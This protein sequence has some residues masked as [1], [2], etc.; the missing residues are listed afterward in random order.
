M[1]TIDFSQIIAAKLNGQEVVRISDTVNTLW[2]KQ[3]ADYNYLSFTDVS[4]AQNTLTLSRVGTEPTSLYNIALEYSFDK[5]TWQTWTEDANYVRTLA[6][7]AGGT[8]YLRGDNSV[9]NLGSDNY[10]YNFASTANVAAGGDLR[11]L[12][13]K[14]LNESAMPNYFGRCLFKDMTTLT[15]APAIGFTTIGTASCRSM[16]DGCTSL[17]D[18][19]LIDLSSYTIGSGATALFYWMFRNCTSITAAPPI[20]VT[21]AVSSVLYGTFTGCTSMTTAANVHLNAISL[22]TYAY[23]ELFKD[24]TS[25]TTLPTFTQSPLSVDTQ[26]L[27]STFQGCT[28]I[29]SAP[30]LEV[31]SMVI[32]SRFNC[33]GMFRGCTS[34]ASVS[35][36]VLSA[37]TLT[38]ACYKN[39]FYECTSLTDAPEL[40][41]TTLADGN[42]DNGNG[43]YAFMF[44][45]CSSLNHIKVAFTD[46]D[47]DAATANLYCNGWVQNVANSGTFECPSALPTTTGSSYIP[48][49]WTVVNTDS[50]KSR[51]FSI[52]DESGAANTIKLIG[53]S[54]SVYS[55]S[56]EGTTWNEVAAS[57]AGTE[58]SLPAN[59]KVLFK[60]TGGMSGMKFDATGNYS[61][62]GNIDSLIH[63]DNFVDGGTSGDFYSLFDGSAKLVSAENL[64]IG[65][66]TVVGSKMQYMFRNCTGLVTPPS[67][68]KI[69]ALEQNS[70]MQSMFQ[71][72]SAMT[73]PPNMSGL[74]NLSGIWA[75]GMRDMF[76]NCTSLASPADLSGVTTLGDR[77][78]NGMYYGCTSLEEPSDMPLLVSVSSNSSFNQMYYG[79]T[80]LK[81]VPDLHSLTSLG[82][83]N[84]VMYGMFQGCTSLR[85]GLDISGITTA[86]GSTPFDY[87]YT[88]C[89]NIFE[90][91]T[92]NIS[93][94]AVPTEGWKNNFGA[95][96]GVYHIMQ[97]LGSGFS[98]KTNWIVARTVS[99]ES[100]DTDYFTISM[101]Y[102]GSTRTVNVY[103]NDSETID[104]STDNGTTWNTITPAS[105]GGSVITTSGTGKVMFRH[106]GA[107]DGIKF[108][109][110][111]A[112]AVSGNIDSLIHG[113]NYSQSGLWM[114]NVDF[115]NLFNGASKLV[116][117]SHLYMGAYCSVG[118]WSLASMFYDCTHLLKAPDLTSITT[119]TNDNAF[120]NMFQNCYCLDEGVD[121]SNLEF[122]N[123]EWL[124]SGFGSMYNGCVQLTKAYT[125]NCDFWDDNLFDD[126]LYG[127]NA[128]GTLG[129][130]SVTSPLVTRNSASGCP[131]GWEILASGTV[132][133]VSS[134]GYV[135]ATPLN[136]GDTLQYKVNN[137]SWQTYSAPIA[138]SSLTP[139]DTVTVRELHNGVE[140]GTQNSVTLT[141]QNCAVPSITNSG[142]TVTI[143]DSSDSYAGARIYYTT[144][145]STPTSSSTLYTAPFTAAYGTTVNAISVP[146]NSTW[147]AHSD[148]ASAIV[149][150]GTLL[151]YV[152]NVDMEDSPALTDLV[153]T[154]ILLDNDMKF[155][156]ELIGAGHSN[157]MVNVGNII[158][159]SEGN[160]LRSF[161]VGSLYNDWGGTAGRKAVGFDY[162]NGVS[163]DLTFDKT[164]CYNNLTGSYLWDDNVGVYDNSNNL[165]CLIDV[166]SMKF[167]RLRIWKPVNGVDTLVFDGRAAYVN[168][169]YG[170]L[171]MVSGQMLTN[172]NIVMTGE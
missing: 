37:D 123:Y 92:P 131:S 163:I 64:Y 75:S 51:Y 102:V 140:W 155:R 103:G 73:T 44:R 35:N 110:D 74:T 171:D 148:V 4:N 84:S 168:N 31:G 48:T 77:T 160:S 144:D 41:A 117:A 95:S 149:I 152:C 94:W 97:P 156:V 13:S 143:T 129:S 159:D 59:G 11:S 3:A 82:S 72:C 87:M 157:G 145:G 42:G 88:G 109:C 90:V 105:G 104:Y 1:P 43:C 91:W 18:V 32:G 101:K 106:E 120:N 62:W 23:G 134:N 146:T 96:Y 172:P 111:Y 114:S 116:D 8:V 83:G 137:G 9:I 25:L 56:D 127:V 147:Y 141:V 118:F 100:T 124:N 17:S 164:S 40:P 49:G 63:G 57:S 76:K 24:C 113:D 165:N 154:G 85:R 26:G 66:T 89:S 6:I 28:L 78:C 121:L 15:K 93:D 170:I 119:L 86:S 99:N 138:W 80:A 46:W 98:P 162:G 130:N 126:W 55:S 60:H 79:C 107:M 20:T 139:N 39:M 30:A 12:R 61:V 125:P 132:S 167:V 38:L 65:Y 33:A 36:L 22:G 150:N 133:V 2:E 19:S 135:T 27:N 122:T 54:G 70:P 151:D 10:Y 5:Q 153:D 161:F 29:T 108:G 69:T 81:R 47:S 166:T 68:E 158:D 16:F 142:N 71:G 50:Q 128:N 67:L 14:T 169:T 53:T 34:L 45:G 21:T 58:I 52:N 136:Q 115:P 7:P 112:F